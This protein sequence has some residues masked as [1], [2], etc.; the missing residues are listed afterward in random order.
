MSP[1]VNP[2]SGRTRAYDS[3][4]RQEQARQTR[5]AVLE[6]AHRLFVEQGYAKTTMAEVAGEVGVSVETV[7]KAFGNKP[8][9]VK[10]VFDVA[11][12]GDDEPIPMVQRELVQRIEAEPDARE[13]LRI[14]GEH[15]VTTGARTA[16]ILLVV[17]AAAATDDGAA[18]LWE[19]LQAERLTGMTAFAKHLDEGGHLRKDVSAAE[20]RDVVWTHNSVEMWDLLVIQRGWSAKRFGTWVGRQLIAAL[21]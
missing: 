9:L 3:T 4:R 5:R 13:K 10:A 17:R 18:E 11:V 19:Q 21:L 20:A 7:Y 1:D 6:A 14:Y 12:V 8:G 16:A 15:L 2:R